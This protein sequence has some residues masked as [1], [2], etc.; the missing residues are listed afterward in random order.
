VGPYKISESK[1]VSTEYN[2]FNQSFKKYDFVRIADYFCKIDP[3][4]ICSLRIIVRKL[5][6]GTHFS[7]ILGKPEEIS[8]FIEN[9][10][11]K[12]KPALFDNTKLNKFGTEET[13]IKLEEL[14]EEP[15]YF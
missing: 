15:I 7:E 4:K 9:S 6:E 2:Q 11:L 13:P 3:S 10:H 12:S 1:I 5:E 8:Q 14:G